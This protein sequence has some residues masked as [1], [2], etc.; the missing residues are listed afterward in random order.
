MY[1]QLEEGKQLLF[2]RLSS[3]TQ[4]T[5]A[6]P[7]GL[8]SEFDTY[9]PSYYILS[10]SGDRYHLNPLHFRL[11]SILTVRIMRTSHIEQLLQYPYRILRSFHSMSNRS[12]V[13]V[14]LVI[15]ATLEALVPKEMDVLVIDS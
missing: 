15:I 7:C 13:L 12:G 5:L 3:Q 14:D 10:T 4:E 9:T 11:A 2:H 6:H 1:S 8:C